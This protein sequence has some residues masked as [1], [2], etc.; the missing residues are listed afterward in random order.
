MVDLEFIEEASFSER[1]QALI[2]PDCLARLKAIFDCV[3]AE[4]EALDTT[5]EKCMEDGHFPYGVRLSC[6]LEFDIPEWVFSKDFHSIAGEMCE[7]SIPHTLPYAKSPLDGYWGN[8]G[9]DVRGRKDTIW[10]S[11]SES[12]CARLRA[13]LNNGSEWHILSGRGLYSYIIMLENVASMKFLPEAAGPVGTWKIDPCDPVEGLGVGFASIIGD[14]C[15]YGEYLSRELLTPQAQYTYNAIIKEFGGLDAMDAAGMN[16][17]V[18][19]KDGGIDSHSSGGQS[20]LIESSLDCL[21]SL[22]GGIRETPNFFWCGGH[23][24]DATPI[25]IPLKDVAMIRIPSFYTSERYISGFFGE[26]EK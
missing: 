6:A 9:I 18:F 15:L 25:A 14:S 19:F 8:I 10:V 22:G 13:A 1:L 7:N 2:G 21:N 20:E 3:S 11:I 23:E 26:M 4:N 17:K 5:F 24:G 12:A 16:I